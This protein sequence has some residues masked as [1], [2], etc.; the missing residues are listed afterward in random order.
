M[1]GWDSSVGIATRHML[2]VRR[3]NSGGGK[4]FCTRPDRPWGP[5]SLQYNGYRVYFLRVKR[6]GRGVDRPPSSSAEVKERLEL[7]P[8][9]QSGASWFVLGCTLPF[10]LPLPVRLMLY[11][12]TCCNLYECGSE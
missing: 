4:V 6:L 3:S 12:Y 7:Y 9:S 2:E 1:W 5:P 11:P 10:P 8:Y